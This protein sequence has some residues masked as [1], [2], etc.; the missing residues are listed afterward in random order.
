MGYCKPSCW[1][2]AETTPLPR[3]S[4]AQQTPYGIGSSCVPQQSRVASPQP[5]VANRSQHLT[6]A[7]GGILRNENIYQGFSGKYSEAD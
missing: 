6:L 4:L 1:G 7:A 5:G 2:Q 3:A